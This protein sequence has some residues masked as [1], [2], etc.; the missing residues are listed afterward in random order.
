MKQSSAKFRT[1]TSEKATLHRSASLTNLNGEQGSQTSK[2]FP[3]TADSLLHSPP[4][5]ANANGKSGVDARTGMSLLEQALR[6]DPPV[7]KEYST[8]QR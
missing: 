6:K 5:K 2:P 4:V 3:E 8:A 7:E 1:C